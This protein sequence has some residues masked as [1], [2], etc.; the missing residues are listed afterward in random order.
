MPDVF[1]YPAVPKNLEWWGIGREAQGAAG[2][3]VAPTV[4]IPMTSGTPSDQLNMLVDKALR[5]DM[6]EDY[7]EVVGTRIAD[8]PLNGNV[9]LDS[10][11]HVLYNLF[12]D[13]QS[14]G[15]LMTSTG[16]VTPATTVGGT[17]ATTVSITSPT[18]SAPFYFQIGNGTTDPFEVVTCSAATTSS[19]TVS[20]PGFRFAHNAGATIKQ[21]QAPFTHN[22]A[23]LNGGGAFGQQSNAQPITHTITH[24]NALPQANTGTY[25]PST[26]F[27]QPNHARQY[28]YWCCSGAD[29]TMNT[30]NLFQ[31]STKGAAFF[32]QDAGSLFT[33]S[34]TD[35]GAQPD[36]LF[37]VG[38]GSYTPPIGSMLSGGTVL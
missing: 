6:G 23:L 9:Y 1:T 20:T 13:Y 37:K 24:F 18:G 19:I 28:G 3:V 27:N 5:G 22:F 7:K 17:G 36:W 11:G 33:N 15:T 30:Q 21:V 4:T 2:T 35:A 10:Y 8:V 16:T 14:Q 38:I 12:G 25:V 31:H 34:Q 32:G 29:F 26:G